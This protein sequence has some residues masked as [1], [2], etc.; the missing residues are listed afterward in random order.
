M[1]SLA[2]R[3]KDEKLKHT[4]IFLVNTGCEEVGCY[5]ADAFA[6]EYKDE[7][8]NP[9]W[10]AVDGV[11]TLNSN[12]VYFKDET[13]LFKTKSDKKLIEILEKISEEKP[14]LSLKPSS[15]KGAYTEGA[16]G[17]KFGFR[18][19]SFSS[20]SKIGALGEWHR[21]TDTLKNVEIDTV[22][23]TEKAVF[24]LIKKIDSQD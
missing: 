9:Y 12:P 16:I 5:G 4:E 14:E 1:L 18:V 11:G 7:L 15:F 13:F 21:V 22:E 3:F 6:R 24:E 2:Q 19:L 23:K 20:F 8:K 17:G 10:I